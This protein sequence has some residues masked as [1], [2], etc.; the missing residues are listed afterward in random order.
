VAGEDLKRLET[1][2]LHPDI[3]LVTLGERRFYLL[4]TA[5]VSQA[6]VD[7]VKETLEQLKPD[8][9]AVELCNSRYQTLRDP[10]RWKNTDIVAV[11]KQGKG[12]LLLA[13]LLLSSFQKRIGDQLGVKPG[14]EMM[15]ALNTSDEL[16]VPT[17]LADR[18]VG[19]TLRRTWSRLSWW[20]LTKIMLSSFAGLFESH[21]ISQ[22]EVER[23]KRSDALEEALKELSEQLPEVQQT[24]VDERD[25]YLAAKIH[26]A[27]GERVVAVVGAGHVQGIT[28]YLGQITD[29]SELE[30]IPAQSKFSKAMGWLIPLAIVAALVY[31]FMHWGSAAGMRMLGMWALI[32]SLAGMLGCVLALAHPLTIVSGFLFAPIG[33]LH[34]LI[35]TGWVT[36]LVE[37][38]LR[39]PRVA[40]FE[41]LS[42]EPISVRRLYGNR[43]TRILLV[44]LLTNVCVG[45]GNLLGGAMMLNAH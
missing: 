42:K 33:A 27:P 44:G 7:L 18:D 21:T 37:A 34:P 39:K 36:G 43:V 4:G 17:V 40:D 38:G 14:A 26:S 13:Q 6:S 10:D 11:L 2:E 3:R 31:G 9:V 29:V 24:L 16:G 22:E 32:T 28:K 41:D 30:V 20:S 8:S 12:N 25:R 19:T 1:E 45:L 23:L 35:A 15:E 5:H